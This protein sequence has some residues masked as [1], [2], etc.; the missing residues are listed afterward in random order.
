MI[1]SGDETQHILS[2]GYWASYNEPYYKELADYSGNTEYC[3]STR[4]EYSANHDINDIYGLWPGEVN[5]FETCSRARLFNRLQSSVNNIHDAM[6]LITY[7]NYQ[8]DK[9][10]FGDSCESIS[11]RED[12]EPS[13]NDIR[14]F[15]A[16][17]AKVSSVLRSDIYRENSSPQRP[18]SHASVSSFHH[19]YPREPEFFIH[20]GPTSSGQEPFCWDKFETKQNNYYNS[21]QNIIKNSLNQ[22]GNLVQSGNYNDGDDHDNDDDDYFDD[23]KNNNNNNENENDNNNNQIKLR[24]LLNKEKNNNKN[25][26]ST[27]NEKNSAPQRN[28]RPS[29]Q[30]SHEGHPNC[31]DYDWVIVPPDN[32][33][34]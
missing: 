26:K 34:L 10:S 3:E 13:L 6:S 23:N 24:G 22:I 28:R 9:E 4:L 19:I 33:K 31:F 15:G 20:Q 27:K 17:D 14:A 12:L 21:V 1:H 11:C 16:I 8:Q 25:D 5:C 29:I 30:Y 2:N 18:I 7:N 32:T